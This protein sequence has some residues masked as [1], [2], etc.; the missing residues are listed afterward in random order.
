MINRIFRTIFGIYALLVFLVLLILATV[1]YFF[2]FTFFK[3]E[4]SPFVAHQYIS[5]NWAMLSFFLFGVKVK[6]KN[7]DWIDPRQTYIFIANHRSQLDIPAY[8]IVTKHTIRFLAKSELTKL[9]FMGYIIKHLYISVNRKD[10]AARAQSME[11]MMQSLKDGISVFI[12]PEGTRNK[13]DQPLL[14]FHDGAFRLAI[15][16]QLPLAILVVKNSGNL[17]SPLR[18]IELSPG[19]IVCEW[20]KPLLTTGMT[21][22]DIP[23]LKEKAIKLMT[24]ALVKL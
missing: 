8:A 22:E 6:V 11:N 24:D 2:V 9:P 4:K 20:C 21:E 14:P 7:A 19:T 5:R 15:Q 13:S 18:P 10:K 16:A 3:K 23:T 1:C 17:L 12:C